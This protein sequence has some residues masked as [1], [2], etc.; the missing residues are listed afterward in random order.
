M[1]RIAV[2]WTIA[3]MHRTKLPKCTF[4]VL[5][6]TLVAH[7]APAWSQQ[8]RYP[9]QPLRL[10]VPF[11]PGGGNDILARAVAQR[12]T[13]VIAQ[14]VVVD[15]RGGAGGLV[16][17]DLAAKA[18]PNGYTILL[19]SLGSVAHNSALRTNLPY[20]M[21]RDFIPITSLTTS[22]FLLVTSPSMS[23]RSVHDLIATAKEKPGV[24]NHASPGGTGSAGYLTAAL[25]KQAVAV[26]I[27]DVSYKGTA[28]AI[29]ALLGGEV[30]IMFSAMAPLLPHVKGGKLR[31]LGVTT[32]NRAAVLPETP[33]L[34]ESGVAGFDVSNW[35]GLFV[36]AKT[37]HAIVEKLNKDVRTV[38][39]TP[40]LKDILSAQG[41][42]VAVSSPDQFG[43]LV[44]SEIA[45]YT[46]I[47]K[48]LNIRPD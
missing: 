23:A 29:T 25:F 13:E 2:S 14:R 46:K 5:A 28:A 30:Q 22:A 48:A 39:G 40:Q 27:A 15:N 24:L 43:R 16:G 42:D 20:D 45:K 1:F 38:V 18:T 17:T 8:D 37:P 19:G 44:K 26:D 11:P 10:I 41:L 7:G 34:I 35:H 31:A 47:V 32:T 6:V 9:S 33:T 36:P 12:L 3:A 4:A 21:V